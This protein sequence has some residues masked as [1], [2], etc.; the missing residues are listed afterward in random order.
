MAFFFFNI[1]TCW[2]FSQKIEE[3]VFLKP[4]TVIPSKSL[5]PIFFSTVFPLSLHT[6]GELDPHP[7][8]VVC[9]LWSRNWVLSLWGDGQ[10]QRRE[11]QKPALSTPIQLDESRA[12]VHL[13]YFFLFFSKNLPAVQEF[14]PWLRKIPWRRKWQPTPVSLPGKSHGQRSLLGYRPWEHKESDMAEWL[15]HRALRIYNHI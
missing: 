8:I 13:K 7:A 11:D 3:L 5:E 10:W 1:Y 4:V 9:F 12:L 15:K 2:L 6:G 14:N